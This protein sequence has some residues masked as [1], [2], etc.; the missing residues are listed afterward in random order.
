MLSSA[1]LGGCRLSNFRRVGRLQALQLPQG[2]EVAG[3]PTSAG[4]GGCRLSNFRRVGRLQALQLSLHEQLGALETQQIQQKVADLILL[5]DAT[6]CLSG[7]R[8][9]YRD[10]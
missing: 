4:L 1:G 10:H 7:N 2:W 3:S 5:S 8:T 6:I 9:V